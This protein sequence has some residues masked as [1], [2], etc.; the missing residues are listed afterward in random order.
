M[1]NSIRKYIRKEKALI[2]KGV[3]SLKEQKEKIDKLYDKFSGK[4]EPVQV[5]D[6]KKKETKKIKVIE[7][8]K[9]TE[10]VKKAKA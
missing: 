1:P 2:R 8:P 7:K 3:F 5:K 6:S 9:E 4:S 10:E